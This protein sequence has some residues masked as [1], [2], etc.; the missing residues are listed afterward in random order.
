[1]FVVVR[2]LPER[3]VGGPRRFMFTDVHVWIDGRKL[4]QGSE[5]MNAVKFPEGYNRA[6]GGHA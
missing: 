2:K 5:R 1:M 6:Y 3:N 4:K